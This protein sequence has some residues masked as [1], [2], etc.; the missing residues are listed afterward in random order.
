MGIQ[1]PKGWMIL[2]DETGL[3]ETSMGQ[4][5]TEEN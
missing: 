1:G 3:F 4:G 5:E 2:G